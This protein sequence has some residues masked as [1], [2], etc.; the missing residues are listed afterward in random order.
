[1]LCNDGGTGN[2]GGFRSGCTNNLLVADGLLTAADYTRTCTCG[3]QNQTS[4][5][6]VPVPD[7]EQ[8]TYF[9]PQDVKAPVRHAGINL[10]APGNR[11]S[12]DGG[13]WLEYP[14]AGGPSPRLPVAVTPARPD[15]FR[16]HESQVAGGAG[17]A[18]VAASGA[19][20]IRSL[21]V[22]LAPDA[23]ERTY[24]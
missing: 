4:I 6:L 17:P 24:T 22:T 15:W 18:W 11:K 9:G 10:G 2:F 5:A 12:G 1:D 23:K 13:L 8:W 21:T 14:T 16:R 3:Y 7:G 19:R 20:D